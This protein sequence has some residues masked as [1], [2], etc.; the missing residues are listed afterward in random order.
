MSFEESTDNCLWLILTQLEIM[1]A[2]LTDIVQEMKKLTLTDKEETAHC[3]CNV[4][5]LK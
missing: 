2:N 1:N 5:K 3:K 4:H